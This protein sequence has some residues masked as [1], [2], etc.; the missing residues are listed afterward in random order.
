[1][2]KI[3]TVQDCVHCTMYSA[4][5]TVYQRYKMYYK[6][7]DFCKQLR[8]Y[9][10]INTIIMFNFCIQHKFSRD[11]LQVASKTVLFKNF[12]CYFNL[13]KKDIY[14]KPYS[15]NK[16]Y[17]S[18]VQYIFNQVILNNVRRFF[19]SPTASFI[20]LKRTQ[21]EQFPFSRLFS[22]KIVNYE[23]RQIKQIRYGSQDHLF[24]PA[25]SSI[26]NT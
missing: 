12:L 19:F 3:N 5:F 18:C 10:I 9:G 7:E 14:F 1:M 25:V 24:Y 8:L 15:Q 6:V 4:Q 23:T 17:L 2:H 26:Q 16:I 20:S 11:S 21:L 22:S 13:T